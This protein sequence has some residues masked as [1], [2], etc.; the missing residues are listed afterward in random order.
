M[1]NMVCM[2]ISE[3]EQFIGKTNEEA[4]LYVNQVLFSLKCSRKNCSKYNQRI[5]ATYPSILSI[6]HSKNDNFFS[7]R[8]VPCY[9]RHY[10]ARIIM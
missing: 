5:D 8:T 4:L 3:R 6:I 1:V 9:Y 2:N 7:R 10:I